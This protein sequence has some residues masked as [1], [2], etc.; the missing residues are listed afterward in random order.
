MW[1]SN[2]IK[3]V[4]KNQIER[5][6]AHLCTY[7]KDVKVNNKSILIMTLTKLQI[8]EGEIKAL[9]HVKMQQ[10]QFLKTQNTSAL[11]TAAS[12]NNPGN[13]SLTQMQVQMQA[14]MQV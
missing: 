11:L 4:K 5:D 14:Q 9:M 12:Y 1:Q 8:A 7:H 3:I 13:T 6:I 10:I 2:T